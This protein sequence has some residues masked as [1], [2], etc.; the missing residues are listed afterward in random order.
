MYL[1]PNVKQVYP[2]INVAFSN[3][4]GLGLLCETVI[5]RNYLGLLK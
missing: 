5:D 2:N 4:A 1:S 3:S